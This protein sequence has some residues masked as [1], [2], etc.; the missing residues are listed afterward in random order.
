MAQAHSA[1]LISLEHRYYGESQPFTN[2]EG[3]WSTENLKWLNTSQA[4]AD[5]S[6]FI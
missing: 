3:G 2:D 5:T 6:L 1:K 4:L